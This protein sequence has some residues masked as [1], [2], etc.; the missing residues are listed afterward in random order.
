VTGDVFPRRIAPGLMPGGIVIRVYRP[1]GSVVRER[2]LN[3]DL[4][5]LDGVEAAA[6]DDWAATILA[7]VIGPVVLIGYDGDDGE[8]LEPATVA[9]IIDDDATGPG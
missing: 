5:D 7:G 8:Q 1:D 4:D 2:R 9:E 6:E 3:A